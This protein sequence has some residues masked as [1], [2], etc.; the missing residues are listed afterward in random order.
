MA[1]IE[2]IARVHADPED[3]NMPKDFMLGRVNSLDLTYLADLLRE[4]AKFM[5]SDEALGME[6]GNE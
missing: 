1:K 5:G 6:F 4:I 2:V 3:E